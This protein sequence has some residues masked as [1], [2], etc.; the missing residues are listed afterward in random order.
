[1][2]KDSPYKGL[3]PYEEGDARYF[4]GRDRERRVISAAL[5]ASRLTVLYGESGAGKSSVLAAGVAHD[6]RDDP[7]Y[8]LVLFRDWHTEP[9]AGLRDATR[10]LLSKLPD[11]TPNSAEGKPND[12]RALFQTWTRATKR[13]LLIVLDQFEEYFQYHP[14]D[15]GEGTL[16]D[17]LPLLLNQADLPVNFLI[18]VREDLFSSLD[19]FK[20]AIPGLFD[21]L[22]RIEHLSTK[23]AQ[24]AIVKPLKRFNEDLR[25]GRYSASEDKLHAIEIEDQLA[26]QVVSEIVWAQG[27]EQRGVQAPYLQLVMTRWWDREIEANSQVMRIETLHEL[28]GV[29]TIV[30]R[31]LE[32]TLATLSSGEKEVVAE[33]FR[34]MVTP[35]GR[36]IAQTTIDLT[37]SLMS[38][39]LVEGN[40]L[41]VM[42]T[43]LQAARLLRKVPPPRGSSPDE[44]CY[45]FAHD[46]V[47]KAAL[48]WRRQFR[49]TQELALAKKNEEEANRRATEQARLAEME[50][51]L[52]M[53]ANLLADESQKRAESERHRAEEQ[54]RLVEVER[55]LAAKVQLVAA[56]NEKRAAQDR[57]LEKAQVLAREQRLRADLGAKSARLLLRG[58]IALSAALAL[59]VGASIFAFFQWRSA[60]R[61]Q[62]QA[63]THEKEA[64]KR[65][66][67]ALDSARKAEQSALTAFA[68]A[69][70]AETQN[71]ERAKQAQHDGNSRLAEHFRKEAAK[72]GQDARAAGALASRQGNAAAE[73]VTK[74]APGYVSS[75]GPHDPQVKHLIVVMLEHRSFDHML[76]LLASPS[77]DIDGLTGRETNPDSTGA[78]IPIQRLD[79][80][81]GLF[82]PAPD[83]RF[84]GVD[85]QIFNG[86]KSN[87]RVPGMQG[88]VNSYYQLQRDVAHSRVIMS[89]FPPDK[90]PILATLAKQ[91]AVCDRWFS[92]VPGPTIPN[93]AFVHYG[94]SFGQVDMNIFYPRDAMLSI[95]ERMLQAGHTSKIYYFDVQS[96]SMEI[97]SLLKNQP[98]FFATFDQFLADSRSGT[99]PEYSF[100][101][102]NYVDHPG[103]NGDMVP[104]DEY[105]DHD[106]LAGERFI[107]TVYNAIR[108]NSTVWYHSILLITYS[109]HGGFYDHVP[110]P[111]ATPDGFVATADQTGTGTPFAFDRLGV[112]V[113]AIIVSPYIP[114]GTIDHTVYDHA[115][116]PATV[117]KLFLSGRQT[118]SPREASANTFDRLLTLTSPRPEE[119]TVLFDLSSPK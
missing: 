80:Y 110:P 108:E 43:R 42:L 75:T 56:E 73:L 20:G 70:E 98:Q 89:A 101:E 57:E 63:E 104:T 87:P 114:K 32:D 58:F 23:A 31:Y 76:G 83:T 84:P 67:E 117:S 8:T 92:S 66:E 106:V 49:R 97:V 112:R 4:F 93:R 107:A 60:H 119:G 36:K 37:K 22:L 59:A 86:D 116:I 2:P 3:V 15:K 102:P 55:Q 71:A 79:K 77:Y 25:A 24:E 111:A 41:E 26:A 91:Y 61:H 96:S 48:E 100:V 115:S 103:D 47:A 35:T 13:S 19:R 54:A 88:F 39:A 95:Y 68:Y 30:E 82:S 40:S 72:N 33:A 65:T 29:K 28:G 118:R 74:G 7:E 21:N 46:V 113:P 52:A 62:Q 94:T 6:L 38:F 5:R 14:N 53:K 18:A 51:Q 78:A 109:N 69:K 105:P 81:Q 34:Y 44:A 85:L 11:F 45:E 17:Q 90:L 16:A 27:E 99:L 12:L 1:M 50:R 9:T 10:A 64:R